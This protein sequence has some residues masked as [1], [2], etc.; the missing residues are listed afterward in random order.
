MGGG[1]RRAG[2]EGGGREGGGSCIEEGQPRRLLWKR[3]VPNTNSLQ[4]FLFSAPPLTPPLTPH[5]TPAHKKPSLF[6]RLPAPRSDN[7]SIVGVTI[8]YGPFGF[9]DT[10]DP[11]HVCN[12][13]DDGAR[14]TYQ[15]SAYMGGLGVGWLG[16][17]AVWLPAVGVCWWVLGGIQGPPPPTMTARTPRPR[18][19]C[20]PF[21]ACE[22]TWLSSSLCAATTT[23][24]ATPSGPSP[25][26]AAGTAP[27]WLKQS[28]G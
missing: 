7:M 26:F 23:A 12:G 4:R 19:T 13:S 16:S 28:H 17:G 14:Y 11:D 21:S 1:G 9:L 18:C 10:H 5:H 20:L 24:T 3:L 15:L 6:P 2:G 27:S 25:S 22:C 8:D